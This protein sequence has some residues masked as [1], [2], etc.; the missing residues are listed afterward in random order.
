MSRRR[1]RA[2]CPSRERFPFAYYRDDDEQMRVVDFAGRPVQRYAGIGAMRDGG[3]RP[4]PAPLVP[5][6]VFESA[7]DGRWSVVVAEP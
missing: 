3:F 4:V 6:H 2:R 5:E 7:V 1:R